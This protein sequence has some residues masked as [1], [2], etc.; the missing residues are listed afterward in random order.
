MK[1]QQPQRPP[2]ATRIHPGRTHRGDAYQQQ[3]EQGNHQFEPCCYTRSTHICVCS[4]RETIASNHRH[5]AHHAS[6]L[7]THRIRGR[8]Q[9]PA[10]P[11]QTTERREHSPNQCRAKRT[12]YKKQATHKN[13]TWYILVSYQ[14]MHKPDKLQE[15]KEHKKNEEPKRQKN[16]T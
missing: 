15:R 3:Q 1:K 9:I 8:Y 13:H 5:P 16:D 12:G 6:V 4:S 2:S 10:L 11:S 14:T 7:S